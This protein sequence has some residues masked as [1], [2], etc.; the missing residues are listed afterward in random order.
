MTLS[1]ESTGRGGL[2]PDHYFDLVLII[3]LC[4][5]TVWDDTNL[6]I[7]GGLDDIW[8]NTKTKKL[9][10]IDYKST[11][12]KADRG[13]INLDD[14]YKAAYK[15]QMDLYIW[16]MRQKGFDVDDIGYFLYCDGD[17][18]T[19]TPFLNSKI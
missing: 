18:F 13:P 16:I 17:R 3:Q 19:E 5:R 11:S 15:R 8:L 10:V 7:G 1:R 2:S 9:H 14:Y 6:K 4:L 12:Q